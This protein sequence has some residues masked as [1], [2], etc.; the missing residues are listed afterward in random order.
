L[1]ET[2]FL[3]KPLIRRRIE[4]ADVFAE[5]QKTYQPS[6]IALY[7]MMISGLCSLSVLFFARDMF[8]QAGRWASILPFERK[9]V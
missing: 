4:K 1:F 5:S 2:S 6:W 7:E 9:K 3:K 8:S